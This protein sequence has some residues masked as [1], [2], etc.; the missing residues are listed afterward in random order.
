M[1]LSF[2]NSFVLEDKLVIFVAYMYNN[3]TLFDV[4][5]M[6]DPNLY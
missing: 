4:L 3:T 6:L 5:L 1:P 2:L